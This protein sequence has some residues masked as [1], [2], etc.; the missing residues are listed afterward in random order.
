MALYKNDGSGQFANVTETA[1]LNVSLYGMGV[2][3]GDY[4]NDGWVDVFF[5]AVG[6]NYLFHNRHGFFEDVTAEAGVAGGAEAWSSAAAFFDMDKDGDLDLFVANYVEWSRELDF[7]VDYRLTGVGRAYG[8]PTNFGGSFSFLYRNNGDGTFTDVAESAG[9]QVAH[10]TTGKPVG[11]GL[12]VA[13]IDVDRDGWLDVFVANDTVRNFFFHNQ[14]DGSFAEVGTQFGLAF[15][16]DGNATG[17]MGIDAGLYRNDDTPGFVIGNFAGEMSSLYLSQGLPSLYADGALVDGIGAATR[18]PL[19]FGLFLFDADLDGRL[20]LLQANGHLEEEISVLQPSQAYRQAAQLFWNAG[21]Q[22]PTTFVLVPAEQTAD[23]ATPI[24]GRGAAYADIDAD[25]DLD[26]VLT[27]VGGRPVLLRND[28]HTRHHWVRLQLR[29]Q[30]S[31][32]D[33]I[34]AWVELTAGGITQRRQVMPTRSYLSQ[35][36]LPITIGLGTATRIERLHIEWPDGTVQERTDVSPDS[37]VVIEQPTP[38]A[39][40]WAALGVPLQG[41][42]KRNQT[43]GKLGRRGLR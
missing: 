22:A 8:P 21:P 36:E 18:L 7:Q 42:G 12:A 34:G 38:R 40:P 4:D 26:A 1:G 16:R 6:K 37:G 27:Q 2:A 9:T 41:V 39:V 5:S 43:A 17:A 28:Q 29:S 14:G 24:V 23:L 11:K 31:N 25:G 3:V 10:A 15:D 19:T 33:A 30:S 20:D 32:R 35:V 13:P